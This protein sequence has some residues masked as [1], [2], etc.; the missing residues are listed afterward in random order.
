VG[1]QKFFRAKNQLSF[2]NIQKKFFLPKIHQNL[3]ENHHYIKAQQIF[4]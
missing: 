2:R 3:E 1:P 4:V